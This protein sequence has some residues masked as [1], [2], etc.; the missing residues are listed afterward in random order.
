MDEGYEDFKWL[1]FAKIKLSYTSVANK[2]YNKIMDTGICV[3]ECPKQNATA[4][5]IKDIAYGGIELLTDI[6][7]DV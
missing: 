4:D 5:E 6:D 3:K 1:Y 7:F 2:E